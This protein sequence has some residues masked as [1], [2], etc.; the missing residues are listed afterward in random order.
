M[1]LTLKTAK[2]LGVK[3]RLD[4]KESIYGGAKYIAQLIRIIPE[5]VVGEN[6][7][8]FAIAAYNV[9]LGH[10]YDARKLTTKMGNNPS[11]WKDL[12]LALPLLSQKKYYRDL[13]YGYARG[14]EP[15]RY[16]NAIIEYRSILEELKKTK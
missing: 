9:G 13:K 7:L 8:Y 4:A 1:M 16:V 11:L 3:S 10:I 5:D 12:K 15:V 6:R 2:N 14:L